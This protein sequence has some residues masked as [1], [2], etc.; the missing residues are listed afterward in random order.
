MIALF[1][2]PRTRDFVEDACRR[3]RIT[4]HFVVYSEDC[5]GPANP[6][7]PASRAESAFREQVRLEILR[8]E[9]DIVVSSVTRDSYA[10]VDSRLEPMID[11]LG[12][13]FVGP[14]ERAVEIC[15]DKLKTKLM[16]KL[17]MVEAPR[18][19]EPQTPRALDAL[20][21][22]ADSTMLLKGRRGI[23]AGIGQTVLSRNCRIDDAS[24]NS[25]FVEE[26]VSGIE[27]SKNVVSRPD[28][29]VL[30]YPP[31]IKGSTDQGG[32]HPLERVRF[33]APGMFGAID[34]IISD[35]CV[36]IVRYLGY[37]GVMEVEFVIRHDKCY[38][39]EINPR[40][41]G[42]LRAAWFA[43]LVNPYSF[44]LARPAPCEMVTHAP[45]VRWA[46]EEPLMAPIEAGPSGR[47]TDWFIDV[48]ALPVGRQYGK[49]LLSGP[50]IVETVRRRRE[51]GV[52]DTPSNTIEKIQALFT[53]CRCQL[54]CER[55][56]PARSYAG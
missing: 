39:L 9:V 22:A 36:S 29:Q 13:S 51:L 30:L 24:L 26:C 31:V 46:V 2:N 53:E 33:V 18:Y 14:S 55:P 5:A 44:L 45:A 56:Q 16:C 43:T 54:D 32:S 11:A 4:P 40:V 20:L 7:G 15:C 10:A 28:G 49:F 42:T 25:C 35:I 50:S 23:G 37:R 17:L 6:G 47:E 21:D 38:L 8:R 3:D 48:F 52:P 19:W 34:E 12:V 1:T 41:S 27:V